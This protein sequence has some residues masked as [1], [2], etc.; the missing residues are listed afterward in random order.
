MNGTVYEIIRDAIQHKKVIEATYRQ[1]VRMM[2]PHVLGRKRGRIQA[3]FYQFA[4][5]STTGLGYQGAF[6]SL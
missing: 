5:D 2:C 3:L 1:R 4:G 6:F